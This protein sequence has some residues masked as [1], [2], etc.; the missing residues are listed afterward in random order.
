MLVSSFD[1]ATVDRVRA[2]APDVRTGFLS[3][4]LRTRLERWWSPMAHGHPRC[5]PTSGP[6]VNVDVAAL[7][8]THAHD[9]GVEVNVW[10]V[11]DAAEIVR[12]AAAG[13][14]A[15]ITDVPDLSRCRRSGARWRTVRA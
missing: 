15:L 12:L 1:L 9:H 10:T 11:N 7:A 4:G 3:F 8:A 14:D 2:L 13:V 5:T 6:V